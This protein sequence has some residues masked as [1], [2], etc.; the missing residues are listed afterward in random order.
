MAA[1]GG[2][3]SATGGWLY[4]DA[5]RSWTL[6]PRP[7]DAPARPDSAVWA[8]DLLVVVGGS[9]PGRGLERPQRVQGAWALLLR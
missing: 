4:D 3:V 9:E 6:L 7:D 8:G 5:A 1:L 2:A